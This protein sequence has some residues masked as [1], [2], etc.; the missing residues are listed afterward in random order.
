VL[1]AHEDESFPV[2]GR[3]YALPEASIAGLNAAPQT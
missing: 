3:L 1:L 2:D